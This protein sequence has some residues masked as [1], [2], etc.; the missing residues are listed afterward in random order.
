MS[1]ILRVPS[2]VQDRQRFNRFGQFRRQQFALCHRPE[3]TFT[4]LHVLAF[5]GV[6]RVNAHTITVLV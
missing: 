2:P 5:N 4:G 3:H 1:V 6:A